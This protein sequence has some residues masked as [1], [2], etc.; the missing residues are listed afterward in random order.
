MKLK[1]NTVDK[2]LRS[3][4]L[5]IVNLVEPDSRVIE[6]GCGNGDLLFKLANKIEEG[7][8]I[9]KGRY[10]ANKECRWIEHELSRQQH[11]S[12][13]TSCSLSTYK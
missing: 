7:I 6:F 9:N 3:I 1:V 10:K 11:D 8:G 13:T 4:L 2:Y 12:G 5:Q